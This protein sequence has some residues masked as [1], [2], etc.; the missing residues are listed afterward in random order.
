MSEPITF[1]YEGTKYTLE[2]NR[3][4]AVIAETQFDINITSDHGFGLSQAPD[5]FY[6][7]L[8]MHHPN[9]K[10]NVADGI[11]DLMGDKVDLIRGLIGLLTD[12]LRGI[13]EDPA[14]GNVIGW[15]RSK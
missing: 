11:Y 2:F 9:I 1:D 6:C 8:L 7:S 3:Q 15:K 5:L 13:V 10:R 12:T 4:T 14:E